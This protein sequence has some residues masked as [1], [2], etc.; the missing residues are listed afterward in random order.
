MLTERNHGNKKEFSFRKTQS[1]LQINEV[2]CKTMI[3][4]KVHATKNKKKIIVIAIYIPITGQFNH[5]FHQLLT[6]KYIYN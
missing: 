3:I 5:I 4:S 6:K 2:L 1:E